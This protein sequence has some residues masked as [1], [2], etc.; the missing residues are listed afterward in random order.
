MMYV[1]KST[2]KFLNNIGVKTI[3]DLASCKK[4]FLILKL[5]KS[6]AML[7]DF[8]HGIADDNV[9][10][11]YDNK[12]VKSIS[13]DI[14]FPR[15]LTGIEDIKF[16]VRLISE[17]VATRLKKSG[18]FAYTV[19]VQIKDVNLNKISRQK[20]IRIATNLISEIYKISLEIIKENWDTKEPIRMLSIGVTNFTKNKLQ[21]EQI[22][23]FDKVKKDDNKQE[24]IENAIINIKE[25]IGRDS[26]TVASFL[27]SDLAKNTHLRQNYKDK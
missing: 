3:G 19:Q 11:I 25:K 23:F 1:G 18:F 4:D 24:K 21:D 26:L 9:N 7:Y 13:N 27:N 10:S 12:E 22:S 16:G 2:A 8:A 20:K 5:G 6:G 15:N 17:S 14:T